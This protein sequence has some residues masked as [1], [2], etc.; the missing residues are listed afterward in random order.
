MR[1]PT[2]RGMDSTARVSEPPPYR[3]I[4]FVPVDIACDSTA[5]GGF[6]LRSRMPL[7]PH[8]SSLS[9][10]FPAAVE[11]GPDRAF[12]AERAGDGWRTLTYSAARPIVDRVAAAVLA[13]GLSAER[14][15]MVL[16]GN[17]I[18]HALLM[19]ASYTSRYP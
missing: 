6:P 5:G 9:R 19:L 3:P 14:P 1:R 15:V 4:A 13:R 11:A 12:L 8:D 18:E 10:M 2:N 17:S 16:S 7:A